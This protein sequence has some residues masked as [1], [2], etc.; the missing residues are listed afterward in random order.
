MLQ[1]ADAAGEYVCDENTGWQ[2]FLDA[3]ERERLA[4]NVLIFANA[5]FDIHQLRAAGIADLLNDTF[6]VHDVQTLARVALPGRYI[7]KLEAL[8]DDLLGADSTVAQRELKAAAAAHKLSWSKEHKDYYSLWK[9][10]P[11]LM[12]RYGKEDVRLTWDLWAFIWART[13]ATDRE[14][15]RFE[16]AEVAPLLRAAERDGVRVHQPRLAELKA[17]L[18]DERDE[19]RCELLALG[20]SEEAMGADAELNDDG[21]VSTPRQAASTKALLADLLAAGVP[22]YKTTPKSKPPPDHTLAVNK[23]ALREFEDRFPIVGKLMEWRSRNQTLKTYVRALETADPN[24]HT[25]FSQCEART[26][27]MSARRP[28]VQNLPRTKGVRDVLIP[29]PGNAFVVVDY[30]S[31]EVRVLAYYLADAGLIAQLDDGLDMHSRTAAAVNGGAYEDYVK[32][33]PRDN[34]RTIAKT[35]T[36]CVPQTGAEILTRRGWLSHAEVV[37]GDETLGYNAGRAEWTR[38]LG[39]HRFDDAPVLRIGHSSFEARCTPGHRWLV[40]RRGWANGRAYTAPEL[41]P[42][43]ALTSEHRIIAAAPAAGGT[44]DVTPDEA[45]V[46]AWVFTDGSLR[47]APLGNGPSQAGGRR[48][49]HGASII[50]KKQP[51]VD[52]I[53]ALLARC[54]ADAGETRRQDGAHVFALRSPWVRELWRRAGVATKRDDLTAFVLGLS[55]AA[56]SAFVAACMAAEGHET[57][58]GRRTFHQNE[59]ALLDA[60][61]LAAFMEGR[62]ATKRTRGTIPGGTATHGT[63]TLKRPEVGMQRTTVEPDGTAPVWCVTTELGSW[64]MRQGADIMLT[65]NTALYGGGGPLLAARLGVSVAEAYA[66]KRKVLDAI[67]GYWD[68]EDRVKAGVRRRAWPHVKTILGRRLYVPKDYVGPNTLIQ[69]TSAEIMKLGMVAAAPV[70]AEAGYRIKLIVH[71]ELVAEGPADAAPDALAATITA[72]QDA[73][74]LTPRLMATG[75]WSTDSY[76]QSK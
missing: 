9:L 58:K 51:H 7:Y 71:D 8:G 4:D 25:S 11:E 32:G 23:D 47:I 65:G 75:S 14:V 59:G 3:L 12:E 73:W 27:R 56:R 63:V 31:I 6:R 5:S 44:L 76:G 43:E 54:G 40:E 41:L 22:L 46:I 64:T 16:I 55:I 2:P 52:N 21:E 1:W 17:R 67:P 69:G 20:L 26:S 15:Y 61:Q 24:V 35:T 18:E 30:D 57:P 28:N 33:G 36:F 70:L 38:V 62:R 72:M 19:L 68:F 66:I 39:V 34:D 13:S 10:C 74:P 29:D 49:H 50:Q 53:R 37:A 48:Q 42:V 60:F 45:A